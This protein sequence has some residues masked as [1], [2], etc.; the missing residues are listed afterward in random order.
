M[1]WEAKIFSVKAL[2]YQIVDVH[3]ALTIFTER[4]RHNPCIAHEAVTLSQQL[5]DFSFISRLVLCA[6]PN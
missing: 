2:G 5:K 6:V 3:D 1:H 4:E